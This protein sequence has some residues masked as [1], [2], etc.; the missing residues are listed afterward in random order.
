[1]KS[2]IVFVSRINLKPR[3]LNKSFQISVKRWFQKLDVVKAFLSF[4]ALSVINVG[5]EE[6]SSDYSI[7]RVSLFHMSKL[8]TRYLIRR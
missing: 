1:M 2:S 3:V 7:F 6:K 5:E 8:L 4:L